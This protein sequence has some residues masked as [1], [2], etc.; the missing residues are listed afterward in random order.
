MTLTIL[1]HVLEHP[2]IKKFP[3]K[4]LLLCH[5]NLGVSMYCI[6]ELMRT[7]IFEEPNI[8]R[9]IL[10]GIINPKFPAA[11][12]CAVPVCEYFM[13]VRAKKRSTNTKNIKTLSEKEGALL[14]DKIE[15][16]D[17]V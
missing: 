10:P 5:W 4:E 6:K 1:A 2:Q 7:C 8:N 13:L 16:G 17:F 12:N 15:V 3:Q 9:T 14:R 11:R